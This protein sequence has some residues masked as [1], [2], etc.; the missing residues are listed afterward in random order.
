MA[1][2]E[3]RMGRRLSQLFV[4]LVLVVVAAAAARASAQTATAPPSPA[5]GVIVIPVEGPIQWKYTV[6]TF[7]KTMRTAC[8]QKPQVIILQVNSPGG[9]VDY[10]WE[11]INQFKA[12]PDCKTIAWVNGKLN[13]AFSSGAIFT[14][15]CDRIYIA[16]GQAIGAAVPYEL[17][18]SGIPR[19]VSLKW[20]SAWH[21][22]LRALCEMKERPWPVVYALVSTAAGLYKVKTP[23]GHEYANYDKIRPLL[24][25]GV[26]TEVDTIVQRETDESEDV[27][28]RGDGTFAGTKTAKRSK[29]QPG[30]GESS[31][32]S[33]TGNFQV[34]TDGTTNRKTGG[35]YHTKTVTSRRSTRTEGWPEGTEAISN[36]GEILT[37]TSQE[38]VQCGLA[39]GIADSVDEILRA[40]R[41][42]AD[43][44]IVTLTDPFKQS[45]QQMEGVAKTFLA[46]MAAVGGSVR[47]Q[48]QARPHLDFSEHNNVSDARAL[49]EYRKI[50]SLIDRYPDLITSP[51]VRARIDANIVRI[52][53][54]LQKK[55]EAERDAHEREMKY[56]RPGR[57]FAPLPIP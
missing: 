7:E 9:V 20:K 30:P 21:A 19:D 44:R 34:S 16:Q 51:E 49:A 1:K 31:S 26:V 54:E 23:T 41:I 12:I 39:D 8:V 22:Q 47:G 24:N 50:R 2:E 46:S 14:L 15:G 43:T 42:P 37:L 56:N 3:H 27:K 53:D 28:F 5:P 52:Q 25:P 11:M 38:A 35:T 36:V 32:K 29:P 40:E 55:K 45:N 13:G 6:E 17:T 57:R 10:T 48:D 33:V 18:S 4:T